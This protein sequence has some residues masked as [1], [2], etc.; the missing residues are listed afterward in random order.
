[1]YSVCLVSVAGVTRG[2]VSS[3]T[4]TGRARVRKGVLNVS[5]LTKF[6]LCY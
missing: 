4:K 5:H 2:P 1:M 3:V 6:S